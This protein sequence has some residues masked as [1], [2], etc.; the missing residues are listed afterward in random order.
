[1]A[2]SND[3]QKARLNIIADLL[4]RIP[5]KEAPREKIALPKRQKRGDYVES[6]HPLRWVPEVH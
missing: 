2:D 5:Y 4:S 3:K 6:D 1:V